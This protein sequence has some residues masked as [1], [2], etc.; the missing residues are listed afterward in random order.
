MRYLIP[1]LCLCIS[2]TSFNE[3]KYKADLFDR[4]HS[5]EAK[6]KY[7]IRMNKDSV[8]FY[9]YDPITGK[10]QKVTKKFREDRSFVF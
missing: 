9:R 2:C 4:L 3:Y 8:T 5:V 1:I 10:L 7:I 6:Y